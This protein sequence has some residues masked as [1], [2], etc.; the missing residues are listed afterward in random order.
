MSGFCAR[1]TRMC[2]KAR[3]KPL[4]PLQQGQTRFL[5]MPIVLGQCDLRME[6]AHRTISRALS[7]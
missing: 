2:T 6:G 5:Y 7:E 1:Y 3:H 4:H